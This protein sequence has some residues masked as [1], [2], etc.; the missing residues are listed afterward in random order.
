MSQ[1]KSMPGG[2]FKFDQNIHNCYVLSCQ[3]A[4]NTL[5]WKQWIF[6]I[7]GPDKAHFI[8]SSICNTSYYFA[9]HIKCIG[10]HVEFL[11]TALVNL[12]SWAVLN[13]IVGMKIKLAVMGIILWNALLTHNLLVN[14]SEG[15]KGNI[16]V[17]LRSTPQ[18]NGRQ[19]F[20]FSRL[21]RRSVLNV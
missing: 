2:L 20:L 11:S 5:K 14:L 16:Y 4:F 12:K 8:S 3:F 6:S 13:E 18:H 1:R 17:Y 21:V 7:T 19:I 15:P 9:F 10:I